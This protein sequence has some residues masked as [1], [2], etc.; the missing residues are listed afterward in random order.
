MIQ[1]NLNNW[2]FIGRWECVYFLLLSGADANCK[3]HIGYTPLHFAVERIDTLGYKTHES[4]ANYTRIIEI[5]LQSNADRNIKNAQDVSPSEMAHDE[6]NF[7][8][9]I[10]KFKKIYRNQCH[11]SPHF[12]ILS[13][14]IKMFK[15]INSVAK[16]GKQF[17]EIS[18]N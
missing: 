4:Y 8:I 11:F 9:F 6:G 2:T 12:P 14:I 7:T 15:E 10:R 1:S 17:I 18:S 3:N 13:D 5:L 16:D